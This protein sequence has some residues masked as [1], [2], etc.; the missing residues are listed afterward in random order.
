MNKVWGLVGKEE[1]VY[2][3]KNNIF[4]SLGYRQSV[5]L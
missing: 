1:V 2:L 4:K 5:C 3:K